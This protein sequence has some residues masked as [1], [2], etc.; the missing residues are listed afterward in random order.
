MEYLVLSTGIGYIVKVF[1]MVPQERVQ[2][3][4]P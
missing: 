3:V 2:Y 1:N 4:P